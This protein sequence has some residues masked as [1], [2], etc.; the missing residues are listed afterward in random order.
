MQK[1]DLTNLKVITGKDLEAALGSGA[2]EVILRPKVVL[3]PSAK[4]VIRDRGLVVNESESSA[5]SGS[6]P[7]PVPGSPKGSVDA[8]FHSPEAGRSGN[9]YPDLMLQR[10]HDPR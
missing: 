8:L 5:G 9:L 1:A 10:G 6:S 3:T 4:D 7:V 2:K